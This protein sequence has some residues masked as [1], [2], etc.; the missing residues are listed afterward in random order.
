MHCISGLELCQKWR[1]W[2]ELVLREEGVL[3]EADQVQAAG[4]QRVVGERAGVPVVDRREEVPRAVLQPQANGV[5]VRPGQ[6]RREVRQVVR[7][8]DDL[9]QPTLLGHAF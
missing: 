4:A 1:G 8:V 5:E 7:H 2:R 9:P 6:H 3:R